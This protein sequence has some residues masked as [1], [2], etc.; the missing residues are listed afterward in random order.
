MQLIPNVVLYENFTCIDGNR[1][2]FSEER[3][4]FLKER[5]HELEARSS[6]AIVQL[7]VQNLGDSTDR[8]R[9]SFGRRIGKDSNNVGVFRGT[10]TAVSDP[11]KD[12]RPA[13][14]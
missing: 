14:V 4:L 13:A 6:G 5:G 7:V 1:I 9:I 11:R 3:K 10:L 8:N 2:E 12:G